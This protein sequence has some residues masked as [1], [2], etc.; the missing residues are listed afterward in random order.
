MSIVLGNYLVFFAYFTHFWK[1]LE[2]YSPSFF[3][4]SV[5][6]S[7]YTDSS[8]SCLEKNCYR[9]MWRVHLYYGLFDYTWYFDWHFGIKIICAGFPFN[10]NNRV[11]HF[12]LFSP[13]YLL[14]AVPLFSYNV[15]FY[16]RKA[17][18]TIFFTT[19]EAKKF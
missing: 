10:L 16:K 6:Q 4:V 1:F 19:F 9:T 2:A 5:T 18:G 8:I 7:S 14:Y 17:V 13:F 11:L 15:E 12:C 3:L